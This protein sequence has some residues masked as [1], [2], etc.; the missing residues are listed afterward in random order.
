MKLSPQMS[1]HLKRSGR[2]FLMM[3]ATPFVIGF[4]FAWAAGLGFLLFVFGTPLLLVTLAVGTIIY[5]ARGVKLAR[6][7]AAGR[8]RVIAALAA[9]AMMLG[10]ILLGWPAF[11]AGGYSGTW[12]RLMVNRG[13]YETIIAKARNGERSPSSTSAF[14]EDGGVEYIVDQGPPVRVAFNPEGL[15]L[16]N[17][18]G[19]IFDPTGDVMRA[20]G[21]DPKTGEF[22]APDQV[23]K[24]F[25]GDLV[26]CR[27][28]WRDYYRCHFT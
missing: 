25:G 15:F 7:A 6:Q 4:I 12:S 9:P 5:S 8:R 3:A 13:H 23:T 16:D 19:I 14:E 26:G 24:L 18:S 20:D 2:F 1:E 21:F 10:T 27:R 22:A 17:W 28:I 11:A